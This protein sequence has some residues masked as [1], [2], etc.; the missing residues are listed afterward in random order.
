MSTLAE[1]EKPEVGLEV[2]SVIGTPGKIAEIQVLSEHDVRHWR[3]TE[4]GE[5]LITIKWE[6]DGHSTF[7]QSQ[8]DGIQVKDVDPVPVP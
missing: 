5:L 6:H 8:L 4:V 2:I 3:H 1:I 7:P